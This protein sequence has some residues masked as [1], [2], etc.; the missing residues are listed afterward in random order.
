MKHRQRKGKPRIDNNADDAFV[1]KPR[2]ISIDEELGSPSYRQITDWIAHT[3]SVPIAYDYWARG[4]YVKYLISRMRLE[5]PTVTVPIEYLD[6]VRASWRRMS[7]M[8]L[9]VHFVYTGH[10][11]PG[12]K[13]LSVFPVDGNPVLDGGGGI[14]FVPTDPPLRLRKREWAWIIGY[15]KLMPELLVEWLFTEAGPEFERG[16]VFL[17]PAELTGL[18]LSGNLG[19]ELAAEIFDTAPA[20][21]KLAAG[22]VILNLELPEIE[23]MDARTFR[24]LLEDHDFRLA[25]FRHAITKLVKGGE[26][27]PDEVIAE[28]KD[29]VAQIALSDA[30]A[31]LRQ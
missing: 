20:I 6:E 21:P 22:E 12:C 11:R 13:Y 23:G 1:Y 29:E 15:A 9:S 28:L 7:L 27:K 19:L 17:S 3:D 24:K 10:L 16:E 26:A 30:N 5:A 25:R 18:S 8:R 2:P 4:N 14:L 31:R